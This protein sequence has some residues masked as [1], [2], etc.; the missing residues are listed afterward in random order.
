MNIRIREVENFIEGY[1][2]KTWL[3]TGFLGLKQAHVVRIPGKYETKEVMEYLNPDTTEWE[4][5]PR[6]RDYTY[7]DTKNTTDEPISIFL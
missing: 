4:P 6:K 5:L 7:M 2:I 1:K 3:P